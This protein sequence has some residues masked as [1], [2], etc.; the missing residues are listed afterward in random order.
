MTFAYG[1]GRET[2]VGPGS[3]VMAV[4]REE[5]TSGSLLLMTAHLRL[6]F[7][8]EGG[9]HEPK[10]QRIPSLVTV[11][12]KKIKTEHVRDGFANTSVKYGV[13]LP[14]QGS[15]L[16]SSQ[17]QSFN[18]QHN[19]M[20]KKNTRLA[21]SSKKEIERQNALA[22]PS[23]AHPVTYLTGLHQPTSSSEGG[24]MQKNKR[25]RETRVDGNFM[26]SRVRI[27]SL[28]VGQL[29]FI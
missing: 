1:E 7:A 22:N 4:E 20:K 18:Y 25:K 19:N 6:A 26:N 23:R 13:G 11:T 15:P 21:N 14:L 17:P 16:I 2:E 28:R 3:M 12:T 8:D 10:K 5:S 27:G 24:A 9:G 29:D